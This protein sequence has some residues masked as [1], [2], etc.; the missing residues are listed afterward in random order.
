MKISCQVYNKKYQQHRAVKKLFIVIR[1]SDNLTR[2]WGFGLGGGCPLLGW[3]GLY[4]LFG[5]GGL[6]P[7]I[8]YKNVYVHT[9]ITR[10]KR[11]I[12]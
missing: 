9:Y 3:V 1:T 4:P 5:G 2:N 12:K 10:V 8:H 7:L 6:Y 11:K